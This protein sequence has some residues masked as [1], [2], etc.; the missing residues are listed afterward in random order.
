MIGIGIALDS[1]TVA[2]VNLVTIGKLNLIGTSARARHLHVVAELILKRKRT[3]LGVAL[4]SVLLNGG[5]GANTLL[6]LIG[7]LVKDLFD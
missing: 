1:L 3:G 5:A 6:D 2:G 7:N 4:L